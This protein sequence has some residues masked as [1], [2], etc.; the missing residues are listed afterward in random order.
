VGVDA[1][2]TLQPDEPAAEDAGE[3]LGGLGLAHPDLAFEQ[4]RARQRH[5]QE[6]RG[7]QAAVGEVTA[8]TQEA[9]QL[10]DGPRLLGQVSPRPGI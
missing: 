9:R 3:Y 10:T 7:G 8:L 1:L 4:D 5:R 2:V 6:Q